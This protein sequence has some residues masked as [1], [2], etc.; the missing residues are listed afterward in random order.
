ML[1]II[2]QENLSSGCRVA[3]CGWMDG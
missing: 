3:P 2:F 1:N